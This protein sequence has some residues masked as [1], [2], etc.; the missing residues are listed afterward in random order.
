MTPV[1]SIGNQGF[2]S[3]REE[4]SFYSDRYADCF[5]FTEQEVFDALDTF[6]LSEQK[7]LIKTWHYGFAF[8]GKKVQ[9]GSDLEDGIR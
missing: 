4:N 9:I 5:G 8:E 2:D 3:I 6:G 7:A 1:I